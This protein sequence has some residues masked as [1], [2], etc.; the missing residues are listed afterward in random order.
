MFCANSVPA[1]DVWAIRDPFAGGTV[2]NYTPALLRAL[3]ASNRAQAVARAIEL[4]L[5]DA[6]A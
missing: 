2:K 3:N 4:G 6:R 5:F 1:E